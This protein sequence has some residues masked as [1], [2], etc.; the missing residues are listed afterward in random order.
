MV[1]WA[2][3]G[4]PIVLT[5]YAADGE[6]VMVPLVPKRAL[7]LAQELLAPAGAAATADLGVE[8]IARAGNALTTLTA[9]N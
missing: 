9:Y 4:E 8:G 3:Q 6:V 7:T 1:S 5:L 2:G